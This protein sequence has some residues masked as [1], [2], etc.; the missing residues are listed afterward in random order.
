MGEGRGG[1]IQ[2]SRA[3]IK[4][5]KTRRTFQ[6][7]FSMC[8]IIWP[9]AVKQ[10]KYSY[11]WSRKFFCSPCIWESNINRATFHEFNLKRKK[12]Q[13]FAALFESTSQGESFAWRLTIKQTHNQ[14]ATKVVETLLENDA[15]RYW[16]TCSVLFASSVN[17]LIPPP[18]NSMLCRRCGLCC[19]RNRKINIVWGNEEGNVSKTLENRIL[20]PSVSTLLSPIVRNSRLVFAKVTIVVLNWNACDG[21]IPGL[22]FFPWVNYSKHTHQHKNLR[23]SS[24]FFESAILR[25]IRAWHRQFRVVAP[26][27]DHL[28]VWVKRPLYSG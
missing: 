19:L 13:M 17:S 28:G 2:A 4:R 5:T 1:I 24:P 7:D 16:S 10:G 9:P 20:L 6:C 12:T 3:A 21:F 22:G 15:F 8:G 27:A 26:K 25:D 18:P 23:K 14:W 11:L